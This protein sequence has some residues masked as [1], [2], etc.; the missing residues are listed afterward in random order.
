MRPTGWRGPRRGQFRGVIAPRLAQ[1]RQLQL[2]KDGFAVIFLAPLLAALARDGTIA[3]R[4]IL[5]VLSPVL[6]GLSENRE[7]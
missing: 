1:H 4:S 7:A 6:G 3:S 2:V 5:T